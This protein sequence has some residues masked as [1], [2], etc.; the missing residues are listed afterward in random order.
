MS[1]SGPPLPWLKPG[2]FVGALAPLAVLIVQAIQNALGANPVAE[3][4]N[5][6]LASFL[7]YRFGSRN[8]LTVE[9]VIALCRNERL[10]QDGGASMER[11]FGRR[12]GRALPVLDP[13]SFFDLDQLVTIIMF[14]AELYVADE[15]GPIRSLSF[16]RPPESDE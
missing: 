7:H 14:E 16:V 10:L 4:E 8:P 13:N 9:D 6:G 5:L 15:T 1:K 11:I 2:I 12:F 3:I